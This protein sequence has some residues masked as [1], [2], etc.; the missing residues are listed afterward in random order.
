MSIGTVN[1]LK[2]HIAKLEGRDLIWFLIDDCFNCEPA[3][4]EFKYLLQNVDGDNITAF[5]TDHVSDS[6]IKEFLEECIND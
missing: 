2:D 3:N 5:L 1:K 4:P 6:S